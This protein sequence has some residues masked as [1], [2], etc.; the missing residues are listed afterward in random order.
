LFGFGLLL[1]GCSSMSSVSEL[2][3]AEWF[4]R[5]SRV[6]G[7]SLALETPPLSEQR[8]VTPDD[9]ISAEGFCSGMSPVADANAMTQQGQQAAGESTAAVTTSGGIGLGRTE[10]DVAR[11]AGKPDSVELSSNPAGERT[12]TLTY[13]RGARPG[14]YRFVAGRMTEVERAPGAEAPQKS[15]KRKKTG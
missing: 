13:V 9:L 2:K 12:A 6:F 7:R 8:P 1:P 11:Y 3:D 10:C 5:P 14:I 15:A 4:A